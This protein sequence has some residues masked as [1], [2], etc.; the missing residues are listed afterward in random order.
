MAL[1][2]LICGVKTIESFTLS[3]FG[4]KAFSLTA[5][6]TSVVPVFNSKELVVDSPLFPAKSVE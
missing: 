6:K 2:V 3:P 4:E 1:E 5:S